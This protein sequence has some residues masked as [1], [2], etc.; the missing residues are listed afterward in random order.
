MGAQRLNLP[1]IYEPHASV[2]QV[3]GDTDAFGASPEDQITARFLL[4]MLRRRREVLLLTLAISIGLALVWTSALPRIYRAGADV[5][6]ITKSTEVAP[7]EAQDAPL[8]LTR[9]EDV[10]TQVELVR[11]REMAGA[12]LDETGLLRDPAF[13]AAV[14]GSGSALDA[15]LA[16]IGIDRHRPE[17]AGLIDAGTFRWKAIA[18]LIDHL[19]VARVGNS[20]TLRIAYGDTDPAR[21][22]LV[23]NAYAR[24]F[25]TDDVR[26]RGR[27]NAM[28]SQVLEPRVRTLAEAATRA[29]AAVQAYRVRNGLLGAAA[30]G[31]TEQEISTYNQQIASA[32]AEAARD[33]AALAGAR[34]QLRAGGAD[35][36]GQAA[37]SPVVS[38]LRGQRAQLVARER[39]LSQRYFDG[40]PDLITA[41]R[42]I[43]DIDAQIAGEVTRSL[44]GLE[45]QSQAS[46]QRLAS[47]EAS[48]NGTRARLGADN[49]ALVELAA[50]EQRANAAQSLYDSYLQRAI[51][52]SART[53]IEQPT[54]RLISRATVPALPESPNLP[55][56]L[57]LG[58][59]I[60][61]LL[62]AMLAIMAE[63]SYRGLT[64]IEDVER[65]LGLS[66]L[67]FVPD[68]RTVAPHS[69]GP[70]ETMRDHPDGGFAEALRNVIVSIRQTASG[71]GRVIAMTSAVPG[72]GKST[73]TACIGRALALAGE[74]VVVVD[75]DAVRARISK[76]FGFSAG[77]PGLH[78]ALLSESG[79]APQYEVAG[80]GLRVVPITRPFARGERLTERGRLHRLLARLREENDVV[81]LDCPPILP[82]AESREIVALAD[83]V[84]LVV[85]WRRTIDRVIRTAIRQLP[86]RAI[87][88]MG[89]VLNHVDMKKQVRFGGNDAASFY[90]K[91]RGYYA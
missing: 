4:A 72:E 45:A 84:V 61:L 88:H 36:V 9:T 16:S 32:R 33:G 1:A 66:G 3:I 42:Q 14:A 10:E 91:Y 71:S 83:G 2:P 57:A 43:A 79:M 35:N 22:A 63:L 62:G 18:Y 11:S 5:V 31:L 64:T 48:R 54:A 76:Q 30:T 85:H 58:A 87:R 17:A 86:A 47:L 26:Q 44:R 12:V 75:C 51:A 40:N 29:L 27:I 23:A 6:L 65:R 74:R 68:C 81:L 90:E 46:A 25:A 8:G 20:F 70:I 73:I 21:A 60:G 19:T 89:V 53:G 50:L 78:E 67:G 56:N 82:I 34:S 15:I 7:G 13:M 52:A 38:A 39:D 77:E 24:L 59:V 80:T 28:A 41:R 69:R 49:N 55:L 37:T